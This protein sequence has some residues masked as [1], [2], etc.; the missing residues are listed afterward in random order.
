M[1]ERNW[2][3]SRKLYISM[4]GSNDSGYK[5]LSPFVDKFATLNKEY[6][7]AAAATETIV[8]MVWL[9]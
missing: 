1:G 8:Q 6:R 3:G 5:T 2:N 4:G 9:L 7:Q